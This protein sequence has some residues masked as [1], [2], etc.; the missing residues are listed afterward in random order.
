[1]AK[2]GRYYLHSDLECEIDTWEEIWRSWQSG[3][4]PIPDPCEPTEV[5]PEDFTCADKYAAALKEYEKRQV[6]CRELTQIQQDFGKLIDAFVDFL[7]LF[8]L[9]MAKMR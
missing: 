5:C 6:M 4:K 9:Q 1:M 3:F 7:R 8:L 2:L